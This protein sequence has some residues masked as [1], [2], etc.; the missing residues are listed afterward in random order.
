[1]AGAAFAALIAGA[2]HPAMA[3]NSATSTAKVADKASDVSEIVV[4][5]TLIPG[6]KAPTG[7]NLQ[8]VN[9]EQIKATGAS[10]SIELLNQTVPQLPTF[11]TVSTGTA[12]YGLAVT[13]IGL[14]GFGNTT[15]NAAG[16]TATLVLFNGHR[17]VPVGILST[18]PDPQLIPADALEAVQVMPDGGSAT[19]G[20]DAVGGVVN[21]VTRKR[22]EGILA[23][24]QESLADHY[25]EFN[26][27]LVGG[28]SW[29][30]GDLVVSVVHDQHDAIFA[31]DRSYITQNHTSRGGSDFRSVACAFGSFTVN[32]AIYS[33]PNFAQVSSPPRCEQA[34]YTSLVPSEQRTSVFAYLQQDL[35]DSLR[36]SMDGLF[37][38]RTDHVYI[39]TAAI[40]VSLTIN[41]SNPVFHPVAGETSQTVNFNYSRLLGHSLVTPQEF[42]EWQVDP[43]LTWRINPD[44]EARLDLLYGQ[45]WAT[46][47]DREGLN[48]A[49]VTPTNFN[50]YDPAQNPAALAA[51]LANYELYTKGENTLTS[52]QLVL[53]GRVFTLPGGDVRLAAGAEYRKSTLSNDT[54]TGPIGDFGHA[55]IYPAER[56]ITAEFAELFVPI[57][58]PGNSM[59]L[60]KSL[61]LDLAV[62]HDDYSD[63]GGTTNPRYG[64]DYQP[65]DDLRIRANY[66]TTF[67]AP[68]LADSGNQIDTR[69]IAI[70]IFPRNY[71]LVIAGAGQG[72]QPET[73]KTF[74]VGADWTPSAVPGL[75]L[76]ATYWNTKL[77]HL[78]G[79]SLGQFGLVGTF[80]TPYNL[81]GVGVIFPNSQFGP[82]TAAYVNSIRSKWVRTDFG[83]APGIST[84]EDIFAPG[85]NVLGFL[86]ARR[87]NF[88]TEKIDGVDFSVQYNWDF[89][90]G[91]A[92]ATVAGT[93]I[94]NKDISPFEGG[95][96]V[97]YLSGEKVVGATPRLNL[98]G[99]VGLTHGP[100]FGRVTVTHNTGYDIPAGTAPGQ[101][102]VDSFTLVG[103]YLSAELGSFK[104]A[105]T[106]TLE[107]SIDNLFDSDP[108]YYGAQVV[109]GT[110]GGFANGGTLGRL[111]RIGLRS[112]F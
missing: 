40:P 106:N 3:Q 78:V 31:R 93:Y 97:D 79:L 52:A 69:L 19:Y 71:L 59:P 104:I 62:R 66:Q 13:K 35:T 83:S 16:D 28:N 45:S 17:V 77:D 85:N 102:S 109:N 63:F 76:S 44:W 48:N 26:V 56:S 49:A 54:Y 39:D 92:F 72:V 8:T 4:T 21:F 18:V 12:G 80:S 50:P 36:F 15:G 86:D 20:S 37:S 101:S 1:M 55:T 105:K 61:S 89:S 6:L 60:V 57:V 70:P 87:G 94:L 75:R 111:F 33:A 32:G 81:C 91:R 11:N 74:S 24:V 2:A 58:G 98:V 107:F 34:D 23:H 64:I 68:S 96:F 95:Q 100:F 5:G 22:F 108:P 67:D 110:I 43:S 10:N 65:F 90:L 88:G 47:H 29:T 30:G 73:G 112:S 53:D 41:A 42:K 46:L 25:N 51:S 38:I 82:C 7:A 103:L 84:V 27:S 99:S 9:E 14:R